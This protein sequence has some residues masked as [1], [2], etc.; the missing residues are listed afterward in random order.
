MRGALR[1]PAAFRRFFGKAETGE[2]R[3][4][5]IEC[6]LRISAICSWI[7][8]WSDHISKEEDRAGPS[9]SED[10]RQRARMFRSYVDEM[11]AKAI[12]L[13]V[14]LWEAI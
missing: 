13:G 2:R 12:D 8:Q 3:H 14:E 6:V 10:D 1:V 4:D 5:H 11:N 7:G 9:M